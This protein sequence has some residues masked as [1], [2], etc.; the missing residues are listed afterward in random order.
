MQISNKQKVNCECQSETNMV[1]VQESG[2]LPIIKT[3]NNT[4][5]QNTVEYTSEATKPDK[6]SLNCY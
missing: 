5:Q 2:G 3:D 4:Q 6:K 1:R